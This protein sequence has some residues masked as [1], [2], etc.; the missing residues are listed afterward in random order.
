[1]YPIQQ[2]PSAILLSLSVQ[3]ITGNRKGGAQCHGHI[4]IVLKCSAV[5]YIHC[6]HITNYTVYDFV[7]NQVEQ[8]A[9]RRL[10]LI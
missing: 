8:A 1:M 3:L 7:I 5:L 10:V 4:V 9:S 6:V 2:L